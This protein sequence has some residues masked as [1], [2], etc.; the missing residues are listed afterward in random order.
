MPLA[1]CTIALRTYTGQHI[2]VLGQA[3]VCV[4]HKKKSAMLPII[5][6]GWKGPNLL[7]RNWIRGLDME[8]AVLVSHVIDSSAC[9]IELDGFPN[10]FEDELGNV[11]SCPAR[12]HVEENS[13]PRFYQARTVPYAPRGKV[14]AELQ[15]LEDAGIIDPVK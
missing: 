15:R 11:T 7:G 6:V 9:H 2:P 5:V 10:L 1:P 13:K 3:S 14:D 4:S 12:L 8:W